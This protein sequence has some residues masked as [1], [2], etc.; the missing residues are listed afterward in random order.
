M[1]DDLKLNILKRLDA[2]GSIKDTN[3]AF[4]DVASE[5]I[6]G[7]LKSLE[8]QDKVTYSTLSSEVWTLTPEGQDQLD[9]GSYEA[10]IYN[11]VP[12]GDEGITVDELKT[13]FGNVANL[14]QGKGFKNKWIKKNGNSI[15]RL[16]ASIVDQTKDD[17]EE[18]KATGSH[19][20]KDVVKDLKRRNL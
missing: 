3:D 7:A 13:K 8:S 16:A 19:G 4:T 14:G 17:L 15:V 20:K 12:E 9:N 18:V 2:E 11:A 6:L 10:R 5:T 1:S